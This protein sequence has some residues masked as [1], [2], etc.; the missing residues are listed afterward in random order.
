MSRA[1]CWQWTTCISVNFFCTCPVYA[2]I[3]CWSCLLWLG[4]RA[5]AVRPV[6]MMGHFNNEASQGPRTPKFPKACD[7]SLLLRTGSSLIRRVWQ[8]EVLLQ[9][10]PRF[11]AGFCA[12]P[13]PCPAAAERGVVPGL[14]WLNVLLSTSLC[15]LVAG[16]WS[17]RIW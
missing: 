8:R 10:L 2:L 14:S 7:I 5:V 16:P 13:E 3:R 6:R 12:H 1:L 4:S 17:L 15:S 9:N 11:P